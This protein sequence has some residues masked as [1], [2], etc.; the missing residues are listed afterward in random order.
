MRNKHLKIINFLSIIALLLVI[1]SCDSDNKV[2]KVNSIAEIINDEN[3]VKMVELSDMQLKELKISSVKISNAKTNLVISAPAIVFPAPENFFVVS[4]PVDG[5]IVSIFAHEGEAVKKGQLI[6]EIESSQFGNLIADFL[7]AKSEEKY[8]KDNLDRIKKLVDKKISSVNEYDRASADFTRAQASANAAY[9]KLKSIGISN[10][11]LYNLENGKSIASRLKIYSPITGVMDQH[12]IEMG[13]AVNEYQKMAT[14]INPSKV[15][16]KGYVSPTEGNYVKVGDAVTV[17]LKDNRES[18]I[19]GRIETINPGL[20]ENNKSIV[21]NIIINTKDNWP[22]PG[23]NVK[24]DIISDASLNAIII[25]LSAVVYEE[26]SA[27]VF[28]KHS[29]NKYE[30]RFISINEINSNNAIVASG[31]DIDDEI[32]TSE[33]FTLKALSRFDEFSE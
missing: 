27:V 11:E 22:R 5:R 8:A 15:L 29:Q 7:Q 28:V 21:V 4:A 3:Q 6:L 12:L 23:E 16:V 17:S 30:K 18:S 26:N 32:A 10:S 31:L 24:L 20:D 33:L 13:Q 9:S 25:P 1:V 2:E 19:E 14:I